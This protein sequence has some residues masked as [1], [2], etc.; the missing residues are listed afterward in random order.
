MPQSVQEMV[1][2]IRAAILEKHPLRAVYDGRQRVLCPQVLGRS[3]GGQTRVLCLQVGGESASGLT[4]DSPADWRCLSLDKLSEVAR[5]AAVWQSADEPL[6]P[7]TC[8]DQIDLA[9]SHTSTGA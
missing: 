1:R 3:R 4:R 5:V 7:S 8:I 9:V 6:R 2:L